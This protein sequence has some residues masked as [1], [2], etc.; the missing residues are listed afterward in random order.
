MNRPAVLQG[1]LT[2]HPRTFLLNDGTPALLRTVLPEDKQYLQSGMARLSP[3]SRYWRFMSP[4]SE[5]SPE[6]LSYLTELDYDN[7]FAI[8]V[9]ALNQTPPLGIAIARYVRSEESPHIAEPAVTVV[10]QYQG[11]GLGSLLLG[12]LMIDAR[13]HGI[14]EFRAWLLAENG[15]MKHLFLKHGA[16]FRNEGDGMLRADFALEP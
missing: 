5:L 14:T 15:A 1:P 10:D 2:R 8:G 11:H 6:W 9:L 13:Q 3:D 12:Q 7:H 16:H 4:L